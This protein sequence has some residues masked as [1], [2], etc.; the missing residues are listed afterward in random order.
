MLIILRSHRKK[1]GKQRQNDA[2]HGNVPR[3]VPLITMNPQTLP[4]TEKKRRKAQQ[5]HMY[6][7]S[8]HISA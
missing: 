3:T 2:E 5:V 1:P 8:L 4:K 6:C 7:K